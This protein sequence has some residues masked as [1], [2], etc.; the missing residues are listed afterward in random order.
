MVPKFIFI[1][2]FSLSMCPGDFGNL[3]GFFSINVRC[4]NLGGGKLGPIVFH[5]KLPPCD[6]MNF[7][8]FEIVDGSLIHSS[9]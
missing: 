9:S 6:N 4:W 1:I 5:K 2:C 7:F 3:L 8:I